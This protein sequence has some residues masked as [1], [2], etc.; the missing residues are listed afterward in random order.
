MESPSHLPLPI[1]FA[2]VLTVLLASCASVTPIPGGP[3]DTDPPEIV[4]TKSTP[5]LQRRFEK[6]PIRLTFNEWVEL[7]DIGTQVIVSPPLEFS[8][9]IDLK[10]KSVYFQFNEEERL[11][12]DATYTIN[13]GE[14]VRDYT[15]GN[16]TPNLRFVFSTG[17]NLDS[18]SVSGKVEDAFTGEPI[19]GAM[20]LLYDQLAD[21]IIRAERPFY[22]ARTNEAGQFRIENVKGGQFRAF[23]LIDN[24][25]NY[26]YDLP[27]ESLAFLDSSITVSDSTP[28][29]ILLRLF[30]EDPTPRVLEA[31]Q[32]SP[33]VFRILYN[34]PASDFSARP[35][36]VVPMMEML[37]SA[38]SLIIWHRAPDSLSW[39]LIIRAEDTEINTVRLLSVPVDSASIKPLRIASNSLVRNAVPAGDTLF[40]T[41]HRPIVSIDTGRITLL[42][43][44][45]PVSFQV[46]IVGQPKRTIHI[47]RPWT[48]TSN[49]LLTLEPGAVSDFFGRTHDTL[50]LSFGILKNDQLSQLVIHADSFP[51]GFYILMLMQKTKVVREIQFLKDGN[52]ASFSFQHLLPGSYS[53]RFIADRNRNGRWDSGNLNEGRQP[54]WMF[55]ESLDELRPNWELEKHAVWPENY[56]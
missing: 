5:N 50:Q 13:F 20:V 29:P 55:E 28:P 43:D 32:R 8:P 18:L 9:D 12:P 26:L 33:G 2:I 23:A 3:E 52:P 39:S 24:N 53:L 40:L 27:G 47:S 56:R 37:P 11:R 51:P 16:P 44:S 4:S 17:D 45:V 36:G 22:F 34:R 10:G 30:Q 25:F 49:Y 54:E 1:C 14:S 48:D 35:D 19:P 31:N 21:T 42:R 15:E 41:F 46:A 38:D 6:Q 7:K